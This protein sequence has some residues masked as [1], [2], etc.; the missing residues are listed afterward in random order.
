MP[1]D[2]TYQ[3]LV[4]V[5][6]TGAVVDALDV[7]DWSFTAHLAWSEADACDVTVSLP[8][9]DRAGQIVRTSLRS[10][11]LGMSTY[12]LVIVRERTAL[13]AGPVVTMGWDADG[14]TIG[15][16]KP[17]WIL[18]RRIIC[19][20]GYE[21]NP[22]NPAAD[23]TYTLAPRDRVIALI[24]QATTGTGRTLPFTLPA[25]SG[26]TSAEPVLYRGIDLRTGMETVKEIVEGDGGPDV[27]FDAGL[28]N[29]LATLG[30]SVSIGDPTIGEANPY[31]VWTYPAVLV[32]GDRDNSETVTTAYAVG[33]TPRG[34]AGDENPVRILQVA[35][36]AP[37]APALVLERADRTTV[38]ETNPTLLGASVRSYLDTYREPAERLSLVTT[39]DD[40]PRY[41]ES[42]QLGDTCEI[43]VTGH[44]WLDDDTLTRRIVGVT[45]NPTSTTLIVEGA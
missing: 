37:T 36:A 28:S 15:C 10:I 35:Q 43:A 21:T 12:S 39:T 16:A 11:G 6:S 45:M 32:A 25:Q 33:D 24:T 27:R 2:P 4:A 18:E 7:A 42:W 22:A 23:I 8:G 29:D 44:P 20:S 14:V 13:W 17:S 26:I 3:V 5:T 31:A 19:A 38:S 30:W 41:R 40:T 34:Y 9:R 1:T